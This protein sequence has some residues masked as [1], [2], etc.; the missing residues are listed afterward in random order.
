MKNIVLYTFLM[1]IT[2]YH[3]NSAN[4]QGCVA[5]RSTGNTCMMAHPDNAHNSKWVLATNFR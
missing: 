1:V 5:I 3:V 2:F 4:A